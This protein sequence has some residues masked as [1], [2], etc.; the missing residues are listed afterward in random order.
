MGNI[1]KIAS[2]IN[3]SGPMNQMTFVE[4]EYKMKKTKDQRRNISREDGCSHSMEVS[5][6][7]NLL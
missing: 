4:A 3:V 2:L 5:W 1:C 7:G 6:N